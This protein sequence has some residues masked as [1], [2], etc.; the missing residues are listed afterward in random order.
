MENYGATARCP[1]PAHPT[2]STRHEGTQHSSLS[3][4]QG[5]TG[6]WTQRG[7]HARVTMFMWSCNLCNPVTERSEGVRTNETIVVIVI[8]IV[9]NCYI[10]SCVVLLRLNHEVFICISM[11]ES[12]KLLKSY[13]SN[14]V[15]SQTLRG[16]WVRTSKVC[17]ILAYKPALEC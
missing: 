7:P 12:E 10:L 14:L 11:Q 4:C 8:I 6:L 1:S 13:D 17:S 5:P 9:F 3:S 15:L 16:D 2:P